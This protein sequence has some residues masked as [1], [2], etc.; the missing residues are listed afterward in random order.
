MFGIGA[1]A[2]IV[3]GLVVGGLGSRI[4]MRI[5]AIATGPT[6]SSLMTENGNTCGE[7]TADGT[8]GLLIFGGLF[9]GILG[10]M[11]YVVVKPSLAG[12][13]R[14]KGLAFG[15]MLLAAFGSAVIEPDNVDFGLF[16]TPALNVVLFAVLFPLFG[17]AASPLADRMDRYLPHVPL[18]QPIF[19]R[20]LIVSAVVCVFGGIGAALF[21]GM[22]DESMGSADE[23]LFGS[24]LLYLLVASAAGW[25]LLRG[26][27]SFERP[28]GIVARGRSAMA[29]YA[30][31]AVPVVV[32]LVFTLR[33]IVEILR[34]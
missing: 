7:I 25:L 15:L 16:G 14:W 20:R 1:V 18:R 24:F 17:L 22:L 28:S 21:T 9:P 2:G 10:G 32:G 3:A 13:E 5:S 23:R 4:A 31:V 11:I 26:D 30:V 33:A 27:E 12:L 19:I 29:G 8:A 34:G 6:C